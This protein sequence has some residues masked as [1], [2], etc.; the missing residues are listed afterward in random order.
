M[1][2][3]GEEIWG[4]EAGSIWGHFWQVKRTGAEVRQANLGQG[5][6]EFGKKTEIMGIMG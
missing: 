1:L 5:N 3:I 2:K 6:L 4:A